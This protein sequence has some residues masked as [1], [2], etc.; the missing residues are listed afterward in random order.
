MVTCW[1]CGLDLKEGDDAHAVFHLT[2]LEQGGLEVGQHDLPHFRL[3]YG[4]SG[5]PAGRAH[6]SQCRAYSIS[7]GQAYSISGSQAQSIRGGQAY[8]IRMA[9]PILLGVARSI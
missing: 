6:L 9:K 3:L 2:H 1:N 7:G 8:S 4:V 5:G